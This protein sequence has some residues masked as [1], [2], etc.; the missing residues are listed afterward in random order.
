M[1][2]ELRGPDTFRS[3][4]R[5]NQL[6]RA[7]REKHDPRGLSMRWLDGQTASFED[8]RD[9]VTASGF[10]STKKFIALN[11]YQPKKS[12]VRGEQLIEI[13]QPII[14][15]KDSI[16]VIR[17]TSSQETDAARRRTK[18]IAFKPLV[19]KSK[20]ELF[21]PLTDAELRS[22]ITSEIKRLGGNMKPEAVERCLVL[23]GQDL[24]RL[25][26]EL[27]KLAAY[28][29]DR[30][31]DVAMVEDLVHSSVS[32]DVFA[33]TD[34]LGNRQTAEAL[35]L[36][37]QELTSGNHPLALISLLANHVRRLWLISRAAQAG[38]KPQQ[39]AEQ[40]HLHPYVVQKGLAQARQAP[41]GL[42]QRWHHQLMQTD[43]AL[44]S[45]PLDAA[46][47]LTL[48]IVRD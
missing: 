28:A 38:Q 1:V 11:Y 30:S 12:P 48:L 42:L 40:F 43:L 3:Q 26:S 16:V 34:A 8:I 44:K 19:P 46:T 17:E 5:L 15:S 41:I 6:Q 22:W 32:S 31:I 45:T 14:A 18:K 20:L 13:L 10:F 39:I 25:H 4:Q 21:A 47:L 2:I 33:L 9:A 27:E 35:R 24:W 37:D 23:C 36:L 7:F 29:G